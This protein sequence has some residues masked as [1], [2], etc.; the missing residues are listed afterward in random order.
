LLWRADFTADNAQQCRAAGGACWVFIVEKHR[1]ILFGT[2]PYDEQW[3]PLLASP[4]LIAMVVCSGMRH[5]WNAR[6]LA[7]WAVG[8]T[9]VATLMWGGALTNDLRDIETIR[10]NVG[11]VFQ[12][13]NLFPHLTVLENLML[14]RPRLRQNKPFPTGPTP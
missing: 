3:R 1:L 12:H 6:L 2:Y 14:V 11:M 5:F 4:I 10:R 9:S 13:F 7:I 8:L